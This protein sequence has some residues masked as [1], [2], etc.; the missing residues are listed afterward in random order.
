MHFHMEH[1]VVLGI[2]TI[3]IV[4]LFAGWF[5]LHRPV[6]VL[7]LKQKVR[8]LP[9]V[10]DA[11]DGR[12]DHWMVASNNAY[13]QRK[14]LRRKGTLTPILVTTTPTNPAE[15]TD[16]LI[17]DR[18]SEGL[19]FAVERPYEV[20]ELIHVSPGDSELVSAI[21]RNCRQVQDVFLIGCQFEKALPVSLLLRFG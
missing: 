16:G 6:V 12:K 18:S 20:G 2:A 7:T 13:D 10:L 19:C 4:S 14:L 8:R 21:V 3:T 9:M 5:L 11:D 17:I 1:I 15:S